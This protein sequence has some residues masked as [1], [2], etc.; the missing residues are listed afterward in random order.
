MRLAKL[1]KD[2]PRQ[3]ELMYQILEQQQDTLQN[4]P[5]AMQ[6]FAGLTGQSTEDVATMINNI[7]RAKQ[8]G[9]T[10]LLKGPQKDLEA[11]L[12]EL[13]T[14]AEADLKNAKTGQ[15]KEVA[16]KLNLC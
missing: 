10:D 3:A 16:E 7:E 12:A 5:I 1:R 15:D 2:G 8:L 9:I 6:E 14:K 11:K 13:K 4:N